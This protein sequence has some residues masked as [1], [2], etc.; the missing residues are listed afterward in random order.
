M[1][2]SKNA[3]IVLVH[4]AWADG[5]SWELVIRKLQE[6]GWNVVTAPLPLTSLSDDAAALRRTIDRTEGPVILAGHAYAGAVIGTAHEERVKAL[7]YIAALAPD[8]GETV[9]QV[10]Y[11]DEP[12]PDAPKL[13]P[14]ADGFIWMPDTGFE[15]AFAQNATDEQIAVTRAVQ[16]PIAVKSIQEPVTAPAW[17]SKPSWYLI[18]EDDRMINR[19][20]Q[21]FMAERMHAMMESFPVDHTPLLTAPEKVVDIILEAAQ[22]TL[23]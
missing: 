15:Q 19:K 4:G 7:V 23:A 11:R 10:F 3:T 8:E 9:A 14:D 2:Y 1:S 12:H 22:S 20:T 18:A 5:S 6:Q 17:K 13:A 16:R 21:R